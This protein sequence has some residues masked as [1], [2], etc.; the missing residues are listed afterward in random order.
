M[1]D[2]DLVLVV[3]ANVNNL[4]NSSVLYLNYFWHQYN[5]S[6]KKLLT[7]THNICDRF[8]CWLTWSVSVRLRVLTVTASARI[9]F[10][11]LSKSS[12][13]SWTTYSRRE[14]DQVWIG[15]RLKDS[16]ARS[17]GHRPVQTAGWEPE[18]NTSPS[19]S[20]HHCCRQ[21]RQHHH[22]PPPVCRHWGLEMN[23]NFLSC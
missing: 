7:P 6:P 1:A 23:I 22:H 10:A 2:A 4:K 8:W 13:S 11:R 19:I 14:N 5:R 15:I 12:L 9:S 3:C 18:V 20:T 17:L 16:P 21:H